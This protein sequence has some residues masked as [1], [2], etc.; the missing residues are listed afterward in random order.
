MGY[1]FTI[2]DTITSETLATALQCLVDP[3]DQQH[4][5]MGECWAYARAVLAAYNK[6][7]RENVLQLSGE[8]VVVDYGANGVDENELTSV[9]QAPQEVQEAVATLMF[10]RGMDQYQVPDG[11]PVVSA[12][13]QFSDREVS[14][15]LA[16]LRY[17]Q[18][19]L[20]GETVDDDFDDIATNGGT[21]EPLEAHEVD[22][23]CDTINAPQPD[24][25]AVFAKQ[26]SPA[27][28][29]KNTAIRVL[30]RLEG[31][32]VQGVVADDM[33]DV[34]VVD[35]DSEGADEDDLTPVPQSNGR[36]EFAVV[37]V[38]Y[39]MVDPQFIDGVSL[40]LES[41]RNEQ[42]REAQRLAAQK[43]RWKDAVLHGDTELGFAD[44]QPPE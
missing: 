24:V 7:K 32:C 12:A 8:K 31:G 38:W 35:Y 9:L 13:K 14:T 19:R 5:R 37:G 36:T 40:A 43:Q 28:A 2:P 42:Q 23:L 41:K 20:T 15:M 30:V 6:P 39:P 34:I 4:V 11:W 25:Y 17:W 16:A 29:P 21:L 10:A 1:S 26:V 27:P 18:L 33:C 3:N 44:W 22:D